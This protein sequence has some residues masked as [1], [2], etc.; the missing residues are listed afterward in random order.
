[1]DL[2]G[3]LP[4]DGVSMGQANPEITQALGRT[5]GNYIPN[6]VGTEDSL[7]KTGGFADMSSQQV[8][9]IFEVIDTNHDAAVQFNG[10]AYSAV[11]QLDFKFGEGG[12]KETHLGEL[13]ARIDWAAQ[14]GM[15]DALGGD[16]NSSTIK[17]NTGAAF[18]A[19]KPLI[20]LGVKAIP[21]VGPFLDTGLDMAWSGG[22]L[23]LQRQ[24][25][26]AV[27]P[28]GSGGAQPHT[29]AA[30][31]YWNILQGMVAGPD[32]ASVMSDPG[33]QQF[34]NPDGT[35]KPFNEVAS[36]KRDST[37]PDFKQAMLNSPVI[38]S[39][40]LIYDDLWQQGTDSTR[41]DW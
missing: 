3:T 37:L 8:R 16:V 7:L 28:G 15:S 17:D 23:E 2:P 21:E 10:A 29:S 39:R 33:L 34:F 12:G 1:M 24:M 5:L 36:P 40:L 6:M 19:I 22:K 38:G 26:E 13:A 32:R 4:H 14:H 30:N 25:I 41:S 20:R 11:S 35:V 31:Q 27:M 18:D 9:G